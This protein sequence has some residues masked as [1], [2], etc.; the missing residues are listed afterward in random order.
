[1][2]A[3]HETPLLSPSILVV[4]IGFNP[5]LYTI[6]ESGR[7]LAVIVTQQFGTLARTVQLTIFTANGSAT[8]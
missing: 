6:G 1:M 4:V 3:C 7:S 8:G 5:V 2:L